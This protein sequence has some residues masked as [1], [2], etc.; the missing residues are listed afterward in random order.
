MV[1]F[2]RAEGG[3]K[4][5]IAA[6]GRSTIQISSALAKSER[7]TNDADWLAASSTC[8]SSGSRRINRARSAGPGRAGP[9]LPCYTTA[10][11]GRGRPEHAHPVPGADRPR[12]CSRPS[13]RA[14]S[15]R[16]SSACRSVTA[17]MLTSHASRMK[18]DPS[19]RPMP[20]PPLS[21]RR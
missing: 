6:Q 16:G 5:P 4:C 10:A 14:R 20:P 13:L 17:V 7:N 11:A 9:V 2:G 15:R 18:S 1:V 19:T 8:C 12:A 3:G 21:R